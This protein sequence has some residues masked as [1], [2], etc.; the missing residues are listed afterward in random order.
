[1]IFKIA[2]LI[3]LY[4]SFSATA[5][6]NDFTPQFPDF[7]HGK[8]ITHKGKYGNN[9]IDFPS[10]NNFT[11]SFIKSKF[12]IGVTDER[13]FLALQNLGPNGTNTHMPYS[14][15]VS[16]KIGD[17]IYAR[18]YIHNNGQSYVAKTI[19]KNVLI[20]FTGFSRDGTYYFS[21]SLG[22]KVVLTQFISSTNAIPKK[23]TD[24]AVVVS[25]TG[26]PI[27]LLYV[28][29]KDAVRTIPTLSGKKY[30]I[31]PVAFVSGGANVGNVKAET[32]EA[33]YT[34]VAL[35]VVHAKD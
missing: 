29:Q 12:M 28:A 33:F 3:V 6:S 21:P 26:E 25:S 24:S 9:G 22:K 23:V 4:L 31:N 27:K 14:N 1:M 10:F 16:A 17:I 20:G 34:W 15:T 7:P 13:R 35:R 19:A 32:E 11:D 5:M 30:N 18:A 2:L 8:G